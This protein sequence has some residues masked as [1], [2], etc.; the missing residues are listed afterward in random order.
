MKYLSANSVLLMFCFVVTGCLILYK[1]SKPQ[2]LYSSSNAIVKGDSILFKRGERYFTSIDLKDRIAG[3]KY[4]G[5]YGDTLLAKPVIDG[6]VY[7]FEFDSA[8]W[9]D[10]HIIGNVR[11]YKMRI[12]GISA[13][14]NVYSD[15]EMLTLA[16]EPDADEEIVKGQKN[17]FKGYFKIDSV[18]VKDPKGGFFDFTNSQDWGEGAE[19]VTKTQHWSY[20]VREFYRDGTGYRLKEKLQDPFKK[21]FGYF[22][23]KSFKA[24]DRQGE[25]YYDKKEGVL[26]FSPVTDKCVV[27]VQSAGSIGLDAGGK[28]NILIENIEFANSHFG[29]V[30]EGSENVII[31]NCTVSNTVYA[32]FNKDKAAASCVIENSHIKNA[33]SF[34]IKLSADSTVINGNRIENVGMTLGAESKGYNNLCGIDLRGRDN[35]ISD[36]HISNTGYAGIRFFGSGGCTVTGNTVEN[37]VQLLA[38][39]GGIYT[40]HYMEGRKNKLIR[41]NTVK[42]AYGNADGTLGKYYHSNGIYLDELSLHFKVDSNYIS[43]CGAGIYLQNSRSDTVMFNR[44]ERNNISELHI[45]HGGTI[46]NGGKLNPSNDPDFHPD[47]LDSIP[48]GYVWDKEEGLLYYENKRNGVVFVEMGNNLVKDNIFIPDPGKNAY[49][50]QFKTWRHLTDDIVKELTGNDNFFYNNIPD[51]LVKTTAL[52]LQA[53][54][55]RDGYAGKDFDVVKNLINKEKFSFLRKL[56][57]WMG[58]GTKTPVEK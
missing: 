34:G 26:Y 14:V 13:P 53:S 38:D 42:N 23:Q 36:N 37:T 21:D 8:K 56:Y 39:G 40:W 31:R 48:K 54:N 16:R 33:R 19:V 55:V 22:V 27:Y 24:L 3:C 12:A 5:S 51:S 47:K 30:L 49:S 29:L 43:D 57:I 32:I 46:L 50:F 11:F 41:G 7:H 20:E 6:S 15:S 58:R 35:R 17:S 2:E 28:K 9:T 45:N 25:W 18:D 52:F 44:T 10:F 4:V 1:N